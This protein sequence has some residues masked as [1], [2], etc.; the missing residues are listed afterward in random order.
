[1]ARFAGWIAA[2]QDNLLILIYAK[3]IQMFAI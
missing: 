2:D 3:I 1:L